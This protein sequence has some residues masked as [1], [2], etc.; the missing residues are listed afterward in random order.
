MLFFRNDYGQGCI[1][2]IMELLNRTNL[3]SFVGYGEDELCSQARSMIQSK[4]PDYHVDIHFISGGTL[5][6]KT[7][8]LV[9]PMLATG[10]S[11]ELAWR[12][13]TTKGIPSKL[14]IACIIA[15]QA[16]VDRIKRVFGNQDV[17]LWCGAIDPDIDELSYIV[18]GLGDAGDLAY[19]EKI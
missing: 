3:N 6:N 14:I 7:V 1:P 8:M 17:T 4:M 15:S 11:L 12:A 18:P 16:G 9:D 19:G 5:T 10:E 13:F 2:E